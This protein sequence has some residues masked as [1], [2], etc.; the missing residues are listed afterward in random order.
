MSVLS[1]AGS[2]DILLFA[3]LFAAEKAK[4]KPEANV[5]AFAV[6]I[7]NLVL[8]DNSL[9][10]PRVFVLLPFRLGAKHAG[11]CRRSSMVAAR[12]VL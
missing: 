3:L 8:A 10:G 2:S 6:P 7:A 1:F 5:Q 12:G 9:P 4:A 11:R